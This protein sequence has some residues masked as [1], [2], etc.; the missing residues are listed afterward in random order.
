MRLVDA[1][2]E[3]NNNIVPSYMMKGDEQ[4]NRTSDNDSIIPKVFLDS[5]VTDESLSFSSRRVADELIMFYDSLPIEHRDPLSI[6]TYHNDELVK[7]QENISSIIY[8]ETSKVI[9]SNKLTDEILEKALVEFTNSHEELF[10]LPNETRLVDVEA[11]NNF[12][13]SS[14]G[15]ESQVTSQIDFDNIRLSQA[16]GQSSDSSEVSLNESSEQEVDSDGI[17]LST[18]SSLAS[19]SDSITFS[20]EI[21]QINYDSH[22]V[23]FG[24]VTNQTSISET[25]SFENS[26]ED[27]EY[28]GNSIT[29]GAGSTSKIQNESVSIKTDL[30]TEVPSFSDEATLKV[31]SELEGWEQFYDDIKLNNGTLDNW[32]KAAVSV[33]TPIARSIMDSGISI[34]ASVRGSDAAR[35]V[36][37][38]PSFLANLLNSTIMRPIGGVI[39]D[40]GRSVKRLTSIPDRFMISAEEWLKSKTTKAI[41]DIDDAFTSKIDGVSQFLEDR[42]SGLFGDK[43]AALA[44]ITNRYNPNKFV[45][46]TTEEISEDRE[47]TFS[48]YSKAVDYNNNDELKVAESYSMH[49]WDDPGFDAKEVGGGKNKVNQ[50]DETNLK[51]SRVTYNNAPYTRLELKRPEDAFSVDSFWNIK[52][53]P[54]RYDGYSPPFL[55]GNRTLPAISFRLEGESVSNTKTNSAPGFNMAYPSRYSSPQTL[56][57]SLPEMI[58]SNGYERKLEIRNWIK[59][60]INYSLQRGKDKSL[61]YRDMRYCAYEIEIYKYSFNWVLLETRKYLG[62]PEV[63]DDLV[64]ESAPSSEIM[65]LTFSIVGEDL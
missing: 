13:L 23:N 10:D 29:F 55:F 36:S 24:S 49:N 65:T 9:E 26:D 62:I 38:V 21:D 60:Y 18:P 14:I 39:E 52:I 12:D 35:M 16:A 48:A 53:V 17:N 20:D 19:D 59:K 57:V 37:N 1:T 25:I 11:P 15:V 44:N 27:V 5:G 63:S 8:E 42:I 7:L 34:L 31:K 56:S 30:T 32:A 4:N 2:F 43:E 51:F 33:A 47:V 61:R 54:H 28:E 50:Y 41:S 6:T 45:S 46:S 3:E 64:G 58:V 40:I 22:K